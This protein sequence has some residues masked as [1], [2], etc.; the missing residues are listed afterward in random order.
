VTSNICFQSD[1]IE[2]EL[3]HE[4]WTTEF[5]HSLDP[6]RPKSQAAQRRVNEANACQRCNE[7]K[8]GVGATKVSQL[9]VNG[10][11]CTPNLSE[12][13]I[14]SVNGSAAYRGSGLES[15]APQDTPTWP[16]A[17]ACRGVAPVETLA[18]A[19]D[20]PNTM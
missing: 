2:M 10:C 16:A 12:E 18:S 4:N 15:A 11:G 19:T 8:V 6:K 9:F 20:D 14:I 1:T 13:T 7:A 5:S 17:R 3:L